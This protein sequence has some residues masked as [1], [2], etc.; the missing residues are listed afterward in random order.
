MTAQLS[1]SI[2]FCIN[3]ANQD[4]KDK[5]QIECP[6]RRLIHLNVVFVHICIPVV[7][8]K[9][10]QKKVATGPEQQGDSSLSWIF[11]LA[12]QPSTPVNLFSVKQ[13]VTVKQ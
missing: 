8:V 7:F 9:D 12:L 5:G 6:N 4:P 3:Q 10:F 13:K 1:F 2:K 11:L